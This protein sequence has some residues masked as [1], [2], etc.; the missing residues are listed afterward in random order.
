MRRGKK[1]RAKG[2]FY[3]R[4]SLLLQFLAEF[5]EPYATTGVEFARPLIY[6]AVNKV[7]TKAYVMLFT[8]RSTRA[9]H[10]TLGKDMTAEEFKRTL[11]WFVARRGKPQLLVS[12]NAKSFASIKKW[13]QGIRND[14][15]VNDY[16]ASES[17]RWKFILSRAP[18]Y[19]G[20]YERLIQVMK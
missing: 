8:C 12:D 9:P 20:F 15:G 13:L 7:T 17:T 16:L 19:G 5:S 3:E 4:I 6:R 18:R 11:K 14:H 1:Q 2:I 10:L